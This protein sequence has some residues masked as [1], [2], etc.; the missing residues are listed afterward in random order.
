MREFP[1][2][3]VRGPLA[4]RPTRPRPRVALARRIMVPYRRRREDDRRPRRDRPT[5]HDGLRAVRATRRAHL[6]PSRARPDRRGAAR[7]APP[8]VAEGR[9]AGLGDPVVY[10]QPRDALRIPHE[11]IDGHLRATI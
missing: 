8:R 9:C 2:E 4:W 7:R 10:T 3:M 5:G 6:R 1:D 11:T